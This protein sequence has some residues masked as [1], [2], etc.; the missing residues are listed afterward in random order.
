[1][2][3]VLVEHQP[4]ATATEHFPYLHDSQIGVIAGEVT[5]VAIFLCNVSLLQPL[6]FTSSTSQSM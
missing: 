5:S 6:V 1:M 2:F 3:H 4:A